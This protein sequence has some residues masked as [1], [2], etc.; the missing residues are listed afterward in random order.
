MR[1]TTGGLR[2]RA[3]TSV[4]WVVT[5]DGSTAPAGYAETRITSMTF[6]ENTGASWRA[7][8]AGRPNP[9]AESIPGARAGLTTDRAWK[10]R[11]GGP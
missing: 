1:R 10:T 4:R 11:D 2:G 8:G 7:R 5:R 9:G 3:K 6:S